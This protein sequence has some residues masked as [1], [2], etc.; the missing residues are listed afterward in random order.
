MATIAV[1]VALGGT[2]YA[3]SRL[4]RNSVGATQIRSGAVST[5]EIKRGAVRSTDIRDRGVALRDLSISARNS[6]RGQTGPPGPQGSP[7]APAA[8][9]SAAVLA[10]G[11]IARSQGASEPVSNHEGEGVY[12]VGFNRDVSSCYVVATI[13]RSPTQRASGGIVAEMSSV[14]GERNKIYVYTSNSSGAPADLP[15]HL[16]VTC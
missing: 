6:L 14:D 2:S 10:G 16:I 7:G 8:T 9:L 11:N 4:P 12:R 5:S 3:V 15:F 13:S 1:F